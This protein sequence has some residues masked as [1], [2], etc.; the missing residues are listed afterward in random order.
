MNL[1][2]LQ[3]TDPKTYDS[4]MQI[5]QYVPEYDAALWGDIVQGELQRAIEKRNWDWSLD[6]DNRQHSAI[7]GMIPEGKTQMGDYCILAECDGDSPAEALLAAY[8][9]ALH[10]S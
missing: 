6:Y 8:L 7:I 2:E 1:T 10:E 4:I 5:L 9:E 3:K